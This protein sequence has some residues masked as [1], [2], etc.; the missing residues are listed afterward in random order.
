MQTSEAVHP[1]LNVLVVDD[2]VETRGVLARAI[3]V[4][5]HTCRLA[6][7]GAEALQVYRDHGADVIVS[8]WMMPGLTGPELCSRIRAARGGY[9]YFMLATSL[10]D[11]DHFISGMRA[12]ADDYLTKPVDLE[13]L[14]ARLSVAARL[15]RANRQ[16]RRENTKLRHDSERLFAVS[17]IDPLTGVGNRRRLDEDVR[18]LGARADRY[19]RVIS[20][21][22]ADIDHFKAY[23]DHF[24]HP[25]GDE[26]LRR[27]A[28]TIAHELREGDAVYRYGGEE[29]L[30]LLD[31]QPLATARLGMERV[32]RAVEA[33]AVPTHPRGVI[34]I[35]IGVAE[36]R[37]AGAFSRPDPGRHADE[38]WI[39]RADQ[40]MYEAKRL[41][42]NRVFS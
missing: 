16:L 11:H 25:A 9:V 12:G 42:R 2:D 37:P 6:A 20:A 41:G 1:R 4:L 38:D 30:I 23:N 24:G 29:F 18:A 13:Q 39:R 36:R 35:S 14:A 33:L 40:A 22:L 15:V 26:L 17:R 10:G 34:T 32:R 3:R 31:A 28:T 19:G 8:D 5:G 27:V 7:D 21:A